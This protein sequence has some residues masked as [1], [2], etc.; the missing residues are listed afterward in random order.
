MDGFDWRVLRAYW[1]AILALVAAAVSAI[2]LTKWA[3][4]PLLAALIPI[5]RWVPVAALLV[6]V[7]HGG[8]V[9][10]RFWQAQR[11]K[12]LQCHHCGG[13]LGGERVGPHGAFRT[14]L[15]CMRNVS[16]RH[17]D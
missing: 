11:S 5:A 12:G 14:C 3:A 2:Y 10:F 7:A 4:N 16:A 9:T 17:Y 6:A 1:F 8:L 15:A 13:P